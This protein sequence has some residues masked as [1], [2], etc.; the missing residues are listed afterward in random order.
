MTRIKYSYRPF[1]SSLSLWNSDIDAELSDDE[2]DNL[3]TVYIDA[4]EDGQWHISISTINRAGTNYFHSITVLDAFGS[5]AGWN[6]YLS[7]YLPDE[8]IEPVYARVYQWNSTPLSDD[9]RERVLTSYHESFEME[10]DC[11]LS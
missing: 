8:V 10:G 6:L 4:P 11:S 9:L 5:G 7:K 2:Y 3:D 1:S